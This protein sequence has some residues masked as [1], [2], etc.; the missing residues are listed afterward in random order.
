[1]SAWPGDLFRLGSHRLICG[2]ATDP[3]VIRRLMAHDV[4]RFVFTDAPFPRRGSLRGLL[5]DQKRQ[6]KR[7]IPA[8]HFVAV[9][10]LR[11][12]TWT[13]AV[14]VDEFDAL[15][16]RRFSA[17]SRTVPM[18]IGFVSRKRGHRLTTRLS[19]S[20]TQSCAFSSMS[21]IRQ[22]N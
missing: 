13:A 22:P 6:A 16:P 18:T 14:L 1:M 7:A 12:H 8:R 19:K 5:D 20:H 15:E 3:T 9:R 11:P 21:S 10:L 17:L 4:A 2:D